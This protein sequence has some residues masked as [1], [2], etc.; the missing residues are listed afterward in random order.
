MIVIL[1]YLATVGWI[2]AIVEFIEVRRAAVLLHSCNQ[3]WAQ[4]C[5]SAVRQQE[6]R[7]E[8]LASQLEGDLLKTE[9]QVH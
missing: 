7:I 4:I 1:A 6:V 2:V 9:G 8:F 3:D 5:N